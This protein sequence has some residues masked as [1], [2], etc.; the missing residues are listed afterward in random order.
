MFTI[1]IRQIKI[2]LDTNIPGKKI[3]P[4]TKSLLYNPELKNIGG[5]DEY[6]NFTMDAIFPTAYLNSLSYE[7]RVNFFFDKN[8]MLKV[9]KINNK[10]A[11]EIKKDNDEDI[12]ILPENSNASDIADLSG[13]REQRKNIK[14]NL[15]TITTKREKY[16]D[17]ILKDTILD[18]DIY[19]MYKNSGG[20]ELYYKKKIEEFDEYEKSINSL[21]KSIL[22]HCNFLNIE[23]LGKKPKDSKNFVI[24]KDIIHENI[25]NLNKKIIELHDK[26]KKV[27]QEKPSSIIESWRKIKY[28][29]EEL[30]N[31]NNNT[32]TYT[33]FQRESLV[34]T[35]T[36]YSIDI[37]LKT[38]QPE[39]LNELT[40]K[41][42]IVKKDLD[43]LI[44]GDKEY[45]TNKDLLN[46]KLTSI[47]DNIKRLQEEA[48]KKS[49]ENDEKNEKKLLNKGKIGNDNILIMLRLLF[50]TKYPITGNIF[51]SFNSLI[52]KQSDATLSFSDFLPSFLTTKLIEGTALYSYVKIDGKVYTI[53]Q[54][55]WLNDIYNHKEY[56]DLIE[57]FK[58]LQIWKKKAAQKL[59]DELS[60]R[61]DKFVKD[62]KNGFLESDITYI[63]QQILGED[64]LDKFRSTS[65]T[66]TAAFF[67]LLNYNQANNKLILAIE[68]FQKSIIDIDEDDNISDNAKNLVESYKIVVK[69]GPTLFK[70]KE[71]FNRIIDNVNRD[72]ETIRINE[73]II[74]KYLS[75]PGI[76]LEYEKDEQ[77]YSSKLKSDFKEYTDFAENIK[78]FRAP[79]KESSNIY[80]QNTVNE[81]L[82]SREKYK[83]TFNFLM[84]PYNIKRNPFEEI[85]K[86]KPPTD[87]E[88]LNIDKKDYNKRQSTG[89]T[90]L[91]SAPA[92]EPLYEIY[93]QLNVIAGELNDSNKSLVDC[94]YQGDSLGNKL[95][96]LVNETLHNPWDINSSRLY[97]DITQ[98]DAKKEI[99]EKVKTD[100]V[101][102]NR[103]EKEENKKEENKK[104]ENKKEENK[105]QENKKEEN[106]KEENK[107]QENKK[108][109]NKIIAQTIRQQ[110]GAIQY[111]THTRTLRENIIKT[112]KLQYRW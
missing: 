40:D 5:L 70:P 63:S 31:I 77:K 23:E 106:K 2:M 39:I 21:I 68:E 112:R 42:D 105:K 56:A 11:F 29:I 94:L 9:F 58:L 79:N 92:N 6:P 111:N 65:S 91:P 99:E 66:R 7:N 96:Y 107:K 76:D 86:K 75:K 3:I 28:K 81:F 41:K 24:K 84:Q 4:F 57:K 27:Y 83:G 101:E 36:N 95:E 55:V 102:K 10:E 82:E 49:K 18:K 52:L 67:E 34:K 60:I 26:I 37:G 8:E 78:K 110:G 104:Q 72:L 16:K 108:Q 85:E 59:T 71:K 100:L 1:E 109:E 14:N 80:L 48:K 69:Y 103:K 89:V 33:Q 50:P 88:D 54:A 12:E 64:Q 22:D 61:R 38:L 30:Y 25:N 15:I 93:V 35:I 74:D 45:T 73:Y 44:R 32:N 17:D 97:F 53:T 98:G 46:T 62:Y 19:I 13:Y 43:K 51:S 87:Q 47:D 90:I 20:I